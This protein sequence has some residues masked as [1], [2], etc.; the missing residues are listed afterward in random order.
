MLAAAAGVT[1]TGIRLLR[2]YAAYVTQKAAAFFKPEDQQEE[3][4][5]IEPPESGKSD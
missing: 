4:P 3:D 1:V 5:G 2:R